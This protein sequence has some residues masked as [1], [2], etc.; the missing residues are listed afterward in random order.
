MFPFANG[1]AFTVNRRPFEFNPISFTHIREHYGDRKPPFGREIRRG[2]LE[3]GQQRD[4]IL[5]TPAGEHPWKT[6]VQAIRTT[7]EARSWGDKYGFWTVDV[8][9]KR[10][11]VAGKGG[12][13]FGG[14]AYHRWLGIGFDPD[15]DFERQ[16]YLFS[17]AGPHKTH[18]DLAETFEDDNAIN[19]EERATTRSDSHTG[20]HKKLRGYNS[21]Q[22]PS[23]ASRSSDSEDPIWTASDADPD[24][25]RLDTF[26]EYNAFEILRQDREYYT[27]Q[28]PP[29]AQG[30]SSRTHD[31][32][33]AELISVGG[34]RLARYIEVYPRTW[35]LSSVYWVT[36]WKG[37]VR[38]LQRC[39]G[40]KGGSSF[41]LWR[42]FPLQMDANPVAT[43]LIGFTKGDREIKARTVKEPC[44]LDL[45]DKLEILN[46]ASLSSEPFV[47]RPSNALAPGRRPTRM[48]ELPPPRRFGIEN[49]VSNAD[50]SDNAGQSPE[51]SKEQLDL[52]SEVDVHRIVDFCRRARQEY[53]FETPEFVFERG[54]TR[55]EELRQ[56]VDTKS[57]LHMV[58]PH[59]WDNSHIFWTLKAY[60]SHW[61]VAPFTM[62]DCV[63]YRRW[64]G[65]RQGFEDNPVQR[66]LEPQVYSVVQESGADRSLRQEAP[67]SPN[68]GPE[69]P[70]RSVLEVT[71][72]GLAPST[73]TDALTPRDPV[74]E[75]AQKIAQPDLVP[76]TRA[77]ALTPRD[78]VLGTAQH[79]S[80]DLDRLLR[81]TRETLIDLHNQR[82]KDILERQARRSGVGQPQ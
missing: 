26:K 55:L 62:N 51:Q 75:T 10:F 30:A 82:L 73:Q 81:E 3:V 43:A 77:G 40:G 14:V 47:P 38:I 57:C 50:E 25:A 12:S 16:H 72:P 58:E 68:Q 61:I 45:L 76:S 70:A 8:E 54:S 21:H 11:I 48:S 63:V 65:V 33:V 56:V 9:G 59:A 42:G 13:P 28:R 20:G 17:L 60:E 67:R 29:F 39:P 4:V 78:P 5:A 22:L 66:S 36:T 24:I 23:G 19:A 6:R 15:N 18:P 80:E 74:R 53:G 41:R 46:I 7:I 64:K 71:Q 69:R 35:D 32:V 52:G 31:S 37:E 27:S 34:R 44:P 1:N 49:T 2:Q 79:E